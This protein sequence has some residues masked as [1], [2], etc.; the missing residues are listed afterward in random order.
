[1]SC[2]GFNGHNSSPKNRSSRG[3]F[4]HKRDPPPYITRN[5]PRFLIE[6]RQPLIT[7]SDTLMTLPFQKTEILSRYLS[8]YCAMVRISKSLEEIQRVDKNR[9]QELRSIISAILSSLAPFSSLRRILWR[10]DTFVRNHLFQ[11]KGKP[12]WFAFSFWESPNDQSLNLKHAKAIS[13]TKRRK[14]NGGIQNQLKTE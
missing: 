13:P 12:K 9:F 7:L 11:S 14:M 5:D 3:F 4:V 2:R 8:T 1:M 6:S 10:S